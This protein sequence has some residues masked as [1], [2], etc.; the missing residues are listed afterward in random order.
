[1]ESIYPKLRNIFAITNDPSNVL[2]AKIHKTPAKPRVSWIQFSLPKRF[3]GTTISLDDLRAQKVFI[4]YASLVDL[5]FF[6]FM[7]SPPPQ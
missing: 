1:M 3:I 5:F 6:F 7:P 2:I 4:S